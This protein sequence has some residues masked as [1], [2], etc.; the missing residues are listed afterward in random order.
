MTPDDDTSANLS[1]LVIVESQSM[2]WTPARQPGMFK[3]PFESNGS[4]DRGR[5]TALYRIEAG[6]SLSDRV[7]DGRLE[8]LTIKGSLTLN[9]SHH[10]PGVYLRMPPGST[11]ELTSTEGC[12]FF[13][14]TRPG[15]GNEKSTLIVDTNDRSK[16]EAWGGRGNQRIT[17]SDPAEPDVGMWLGYMFPG[18]QAPEHSHS[19]GE[20]IFVLHGE[21]ADQTACC[22]AGTWIRYP[23]EYTHSPA[24][25]ADGAL[26]LVREGDVGA[27]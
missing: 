13:L 15:V 7:F 22:G 19:N 10:E 6:A 20:E 8:I 16:W 26:L 14:R 25:R 27:R 4:G 24:A 5:E 1:E 3:K 11:V 9:G 2:A 21:L 17:M 18:H 12:V 23:V